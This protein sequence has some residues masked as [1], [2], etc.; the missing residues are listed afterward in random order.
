MDVRLLHW[1]CRDDEA[2]ALALRKE[3]R[4]NTAARYH[5]IIPLI[6]G[7]GYLLRLNEYLNLCKFGT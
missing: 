3:L 5:H 1:G 7:R 6:T 2:R 4:S